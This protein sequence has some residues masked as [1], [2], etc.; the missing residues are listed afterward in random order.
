[1]AQYRIN[2]IRKMKFLYF[3]LLSLLYRIIA[4]KLSNFLNLSQILQ[5]EEI[6]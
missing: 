2:E 3:I 4:I 5:T 1:M 6:Y